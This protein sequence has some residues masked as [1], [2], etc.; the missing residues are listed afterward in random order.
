MST[1]EHNVCPDNSGQI[2]GV[3]TWASANDPLSTMEEIR[4]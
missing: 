2:H 3:S 1:G 4:R